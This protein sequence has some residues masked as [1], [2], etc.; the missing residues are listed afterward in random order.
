MIFGSLS[1][2]FYLAES[3]KHADQ[4]CN[5]LSKSVGERRKQSK[6]ADIN[7]NSAYRPT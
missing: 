7:Y 5:A 3:V 1:S 6:V 2:E 4:C